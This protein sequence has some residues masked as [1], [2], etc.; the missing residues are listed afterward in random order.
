LAESSAYAQ[1]EEYYDAI[2]ET[3]KDY[4]KES[5]LIR[6]LIGRHKK[7]RDRS[8]LDIACG[9]GRHLSYLRKWFTVEG[10]DADPKMLTIARKRN[11]QIRFHRANMVKFQLPYKYDAITCLFSAIGYVRTL[12]KL[13]A[14]IRSMARHLKPGG[15]LIVE[16]WLTPQAYKRGHV[17]AVFVKQPKLKIARI[18]IAKKRGRVSTMIF[19]YLVGTPDGIKYFTEPHK[20]GMFTR[21]EYLTAFRDCG[22]KVAY[23]SKGLTGRGIYVGMKPVNA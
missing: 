14:S 8:L 11:P 5:R 18:D 23:Y 19:H 15:V 1:S 2:Y 10:L 20:L 16:P 13:R 7:S 4:S 22:L 12:S 3:F 17:G 9:T 6:K 21:N